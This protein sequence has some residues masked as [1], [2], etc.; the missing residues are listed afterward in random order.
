MWG[1]FDLKFQ[2]GILYLLPSLH[3]RIVQLYILLVFSK[4]L[5]SAFV[6]IPVE[7]EDTSIPLVVV[8]SCM[9]NLNLIIYQPLSYPLILRTPADLTV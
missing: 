6:L 4:S 2:N 3:V 9:S 5:S 8:N 1:N 7:E